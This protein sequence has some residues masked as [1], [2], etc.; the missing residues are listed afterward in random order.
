MPA[1]LA[2]KSS[3][4]ASGQGAASG[5]GVRLRPARPWQ[6]E[7]LS[8]FLVRCHPRGLGTPVARHRLFPDS[9]KALPKTFRINC[10]YPH[11]PTPVGLSP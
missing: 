4:M 7:R 10:C 9:L 8:Y 11:P 3:A 6:S 1:I 5:S 2:S